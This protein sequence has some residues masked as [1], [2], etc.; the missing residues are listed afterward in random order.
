MVFCK[1]EGIYY[2]NK[3]GFLALY[4]VGIYILLFSRGIYVGKID[5]KYTRIINIIGGIA[6]LF[7]S[8]ISILDPY[9]R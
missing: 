6:I 1:H 5:I 9:L 2:L 4:P 3:V 7:L 8:L